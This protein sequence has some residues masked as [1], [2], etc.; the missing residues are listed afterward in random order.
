VVK[1]LD[2][3]RKGYFL[4]FF[5]LILTILTL[6]LLGTVLTQTIDVRENIVSFRDAS[7]ART[8]GDSL[9]N[10]VMRQHKDNGLGFV[11]RGTYP[12]VDTDPATGAEV[13]DPEQLYVDYFFN[14]ASV[15]P[16]PTDVVALEELGRPARGLIDVESDLVTITNQVEACRNNPFVGDSDTELC[17][18]Y[19]GYTSSYYTVPALGTGNAGEDCTYNRVNVG[20]TYPAAVGEDAVLVDPLD[21]PCNWNTL[22]LGETVGIPLFFKYLDGEEVVTQ[23]YTPS[24]LRLRIRLKCSDGSSYCPNEE[25]EVFY[26]PLGVDD[27]FDGYDDSER[28]FNWVIE[29][30]ASGEVFTP[31]V[32]WANSDEEGRSE[33]NSELTVFRLSNLYGNDLDDFVNSRFYS[34]GSSFFANFLGTPIRDIRDAFNGVEWNLRDDLLTVAYESSR[35][36]MLYIEFLND[37]FYFD[38]F[39][40]LGSKIRSIEYQILSDVPLGNTDY[41]AVGSA[42]FVGESDYAL[43]QSRIKGPVPSSPG[44]VIGN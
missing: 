19:E 43:N 34:F 17:A 12:P 37:N 23:Q 10:T 26:N 25:R 27:E 15:F 35:E 41:Y 21:D 32:R 28:V 24:N 4:I 44:L 7:F 16:V 42:S 39:G 6:P 31:D 20:K 36:L 5:A 33:L 1:A 38:D 13:R 2:T 11:H 22:A 14:S 29:D 3:A 30:I 18:A 9:L 8:S 40:D